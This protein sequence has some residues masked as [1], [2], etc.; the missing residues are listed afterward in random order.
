MI[1]RRAEERDLPELLA[2]YNYEVINGVATFDMQP[3]TL[4]ERMGWFKEHNVDN[5]PLIVAE[6]EGKVVGYASLSSY[7]IKE[8]YASTA[9]LSIYVGEGYRGQGLATML[10]SEIL[11]LAKEDER[12]HLVVSVITGENEA[13]V[14]LHEKYGFTYCGRVHQVGFKHGRYLDIVTYELLV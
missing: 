14:K 10:M 11:E 3:K 8:A 1:I 7:R 12:T 4:E 6:I 5:H 9:E 13:S 2:I